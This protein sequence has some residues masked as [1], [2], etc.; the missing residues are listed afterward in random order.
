MKHREPRQRRGWV[1][2]LLGSLAAACAGTQPD[3]TQRDSVEDS[4]VTDDT[5]PQDTAPQ[6]TAPQDAD[7]DGYTDDVDCDD[8]NAE[9]YPGA[10][11]VCGDGIV[12]DCGG[13][14]TAAVDACD[15]LAEGHEAIA[16]WA[17]TSY[18]TRPVRAAGVGD[19]NGDGYDD[20]AIGFP[21]LSNA[22]ALQVSTGG[23]YIFRG[24]VS[25]TL[26]H[27]DED[28]YIL[29]VEQWDT[30]GWDIAAM[31]DVDGDGYD[32]F[33][34]GAADDDSNAATGT[35]AAYLIH[36]PA[37]IST[38]DEAVLLLEPSGAL[39]CLGSSLSPFAD[40]DG[41]GGAD[42]LVGGRCNGVVRLVSSAPTGTQ[43]AGVDD[44][45]TFLGPSGESRFGYAMASGDLDGDGLKD[46]AVG[47]PEPGRY[48]PG[49]DG[50]GFVSVFSGPFLRSISHEDAAVR[51]SAAASDSSTG[52]VGLGTGVAVGDLNGDGYDDLAAGG[53]LRATETFA[54]RQ[55]GILVVYFGPLR[56]TYGIPEAD[57][58][59]H[60]DETSEG[61]GNDLHGDRDIDGDGQPDLL[62][63]GG[64]IEIN[65]NAG[66]FDVSRE[67]KAWMLH[68]PLSTGSL[69]ASDADY[70]FTDVD[71]ESFGQQ[72]A[73]AGDTNGDGRTEVLVGN[74][75]APIHLF[76]VPFD[77]Y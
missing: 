56:G 58:T 34:V 12:N 4:G 15:G 31:G 71:A 70:I 23:V 65:G 14:E 72:T 13:D 75:Y 29:G 11:E 6:D 5:A 28:G 67:K 10:P 63:G 51:V 57:F 47:A 1:H 53:P 35:P 26:R 32:D 30:I 18:D 69:F 73:I 3:P 25:G 42:V 37:E 43:V 2:V 46:V 45:A 49:R 48:D 52:D 38:I 54:P 77:H 66:S 20:I 33:V 64:Y 19:L 55:E 60:G 44:L 61:V 27:G 40:V 76:D 8:A 74:W 62:V 36:G 68:G 41:D 7:G 22:D 24:P 17:I 39:E 9:V 59:L 50:R 16:S 21:T